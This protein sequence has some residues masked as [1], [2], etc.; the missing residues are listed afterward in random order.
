[1]A[2]KSKPKKTEAIAK[3]TGRVTRVLGVTLG[4]LNADEQ[5]VVDSLRS[6]FHSAVRK[7][8]DRL[9]DDAARRRSYTSED[10]P[11]TFGTPE[12]AATTVSVFRD[13][14]LPL[15]RLYGEFAS[16]F[17]ASDITEDSFPFA[18]LGRERAEMIW[19]PGLSNSI[20]W[21]RNSYFKQIFQL[22]RLN[23]ND[24]IWQEPNKQLWI[25]SF[26]ANIVAYMTE[27]FAGR[28]IDR[29][30]VSIKFDLGLDVSNLSS[31]SQFRISPDV[32]GAIVSVLIEFL[33][34]Q[35]FQV[36][37]YSPAILATNLQYRAAG[38]GEAKAAADLAKVKNAITAGSLTPADADAL[39]LPQS[40]NLLW[41]EVA[42]SPLIENDLSRMVL[43]RAAELDGD[44]LSIGRSR[45]QLA[46]SLDSVD[47]GESEMQLAFT[48]C[49]AKVVTQNLQCIFVTDAAPDQGVCGRDNDT[50]RIDGKKID[51]ADLVGKWVSFSAKTVEKNIRSLVGGAMRGV[52]LASINNEV[53][54]EVVSAA[55]STLAKKVAENVA[56]EWLTDFIVDQ[57]GDPDA[58]RAF[59][60]KLS[61]IH[62]FVTE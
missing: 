49:K 26:G 40:G 55:A 3:S 20:K 62:G 51:Y 25:Q 44:L 7:T 57:P 23:W 18:G 43:R 13:C 16:E 61:D 12:I 22:A 24:P 41:S 14:G 45:I 36:P 34:D 59:L 46:K 1:M 33:G 9:S 29:N 39:N 48:C 38:A 35:L 56:Y 21:W 5:A 11:F 60:K 19:G 4:A 42:P 15:V 17:G 2:K 6:S 52:W 10:S 47:A 27:L 37:L 8:Q 28:F 58:K 30:G 32:A 53:L 50:G 54:A 31:L